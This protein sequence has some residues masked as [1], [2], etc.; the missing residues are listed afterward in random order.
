[1]DIYGWVSDPRSV[2]E[3][4]KAETGLEL[5]KRGH[6]LVADDRVDIYARDDDPLGES[7]LKSYAT[8]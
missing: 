1:M 2:A 5:I 8:Y 4:E 3:S 6:C 7:Q